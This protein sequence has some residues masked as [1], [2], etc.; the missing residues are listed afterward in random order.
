MLSV[1]LIFGELV[2]F[3]FLSRDADLSS[4]DVASAT[5]YSRLCHNKTH[6]ACKCRIF[7][8]QVPKL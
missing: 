5:N 2:D 3:S 1:L 8:L 4:H 6:A 7:Q